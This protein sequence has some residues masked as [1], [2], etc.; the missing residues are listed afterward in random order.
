MDTPI[1]IL[2]D[3]Q[4]ILELIARYLKSSGY[5]A[6]TCTSAESALSAYQ[7]ADGNIE[8]LIADVALAGASGVQTALQLY[9]LNSSLKTVFA[10]GCP[11]EAWSTSDAALFKELPQSATRLLHKPFTGRELLA[12]LTE[13]S[14]GMQ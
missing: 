7:S 1:L 3:N 4:D 11:P 14:A 9:R 2:D 8:I 12:A 13:L 6:V 5:S 10:S